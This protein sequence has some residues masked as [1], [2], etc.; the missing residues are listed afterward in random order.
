MS[1]CV[2][3]GD[4]DFLHSGKRKGSEEIQAALQGFSR[5][6]SEL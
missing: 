2:G 1:L 5:G 3:T 6:N 4:C